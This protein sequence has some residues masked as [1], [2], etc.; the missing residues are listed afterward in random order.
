MSAK[1]NL[2]FL[3]FVAGLSSMEKPPLKRQKA[4]FC[5]GF[6]QKKYKE[7]I[8]DIANTNGVLLQMYTENSILKLFVDQ[9]ETFQLALRE[10]KIPLSKNASK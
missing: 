1:I 2:L 5:I 4:L 6:S 8:Q 9:P 10:R 7:I 3:S